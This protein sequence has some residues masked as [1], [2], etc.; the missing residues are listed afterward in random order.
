[1]LCRSVKS[2]YAINYSI[3]ARSLCKG[4][5]QNLTGVLRH[6][7]GF[8]YHEKAHFQHA[9]TCFNVL[10]YIPMVHRDARSYTF[11]ILFIE[12]GMLHQRS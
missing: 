4:T 2:L 6:I 12:G 5:F 10:G 11:T 9:F 3:F 7:K 8:G 1:M